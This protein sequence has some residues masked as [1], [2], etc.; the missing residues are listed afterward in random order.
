MGVE[1]EEREVEREGE[2]ET[3]ERTEEKRKSD[4][5][6]VLTFL[7]LALYPARIVVVR[8]CSS[9]LSSP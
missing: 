4:H 7:I 8:S 5:R 3:Y 6:G 2:S 9:L 1:E